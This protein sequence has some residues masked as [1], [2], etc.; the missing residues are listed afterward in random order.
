MKPK[1]IARIVRGVL[2]GL[3]NEP[4][5]LCGLCYVAAIVLTNLLNE[6]E[7]H[8]QACVGLYDGSDHCWVELASGR[9]VDVTAT[10]FAV[11]EKIHMPRMGDAAIKKYDLRYKGPATEA[12]KWT[13]IHLGCVGL[14]DNVFIPNVTKAAKIE[15]TLHKEEEP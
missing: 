15:L 8:A 14:D 3:P 1:A 9:I 11:A 7:I 12:Q 2:E 4:K 13:S 6:H 10:Q 5:D